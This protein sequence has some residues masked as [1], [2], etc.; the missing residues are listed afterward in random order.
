MRPRSAAALV[1]LATL[2]SARPVAAAPIPTRSGCCRIMLRTSSRWSTRSMAV[3][4]APVAIRLRAAHG[5]RSFSSALRSRWRSDAR[6][7]GGVHPRLARRERARAAR[8]P[9]VIPGGGDPGSGG[10]LPDVVNP[11]LPVVI[12]DATTVTPEPGTLLLMSS[13]IST[14]GAAALRRRRRGR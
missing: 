9:A 1:A 10:T 3:A 4:G 5:W 14:I 12:P 6:R 8:P 13:G 7:R 11:D 2:L